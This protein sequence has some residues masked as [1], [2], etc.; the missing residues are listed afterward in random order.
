MASPPAPAAA[1]R[2]EDTDGDIAY[3]RDQA[4]LPPVSII[5][6][7]PITAKHKIVFAVIAL[8]GAVA[9]R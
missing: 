2:L 5:D 3:V 6:R 7:S 4:D 8:L 9:G 1:A